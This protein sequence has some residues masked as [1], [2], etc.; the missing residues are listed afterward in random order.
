[1]KK[2]SWIFDSRFIINPKNVLD[3]NLNLWQ[4]GDGT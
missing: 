3:A 4:I 1:M 2:P